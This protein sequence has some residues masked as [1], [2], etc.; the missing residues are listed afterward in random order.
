MLSHINIGTGVDISIADL[1]GIVRETVGFEGE[2][3]FDTGKPDGT[4]RKLLDVS[5]LSSL[6]WK[7][8]IELSE[9]I[10]DTYLHYIQHYTELRK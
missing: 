4:P 3:V 5:K 2:I 1:A 8:K 9:G 10:R 6:G 7:A